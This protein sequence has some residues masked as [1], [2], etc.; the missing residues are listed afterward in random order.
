LVI[1]LT[2]DITRSRDRPMNQS[3]IAVTRPVS[4]SINQCELTHLHREPIDLERAREQHASY[5]RALEAAGCGIVRLEEAAN[6]PDSVFVEDTAVV[7]DEVAFVTRPGAETR[8]PETAPVAELLRR[9][10]S[11]CQIEGPATVD[12]GDV[13]V[14]GR[15]VFVG[16]SRR[17][18]DVAVAQMRRGLEPFAYEIHTVPVT[19][20]LHLKS[21]ATAVGEDLLLI[22][23]EW[24]ER[25]AFPNVE[26]LEV[27]PLEPA[28]ANVLRIGRELICANRF[29]RTGERLQRKGLV[30][31]GVDLSELAKA[32]GAVTCC[33][34]IFPI[35]PKVTKR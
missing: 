26:L 19:G 30:V 6:L 34:L 35:Q 9:Y 4:A 12:G 24:V 21:A 10:R 18:N 29:P 23:P 15:T 33:S 14:V 1:D 13:I 7:F 16:Q 31:R 3:M 22:N 20:C 5:E 25:D 11:V 28:A 27:H 17:T 8:R 32:E 2:I